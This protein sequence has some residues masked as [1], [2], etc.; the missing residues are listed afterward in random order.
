MKNSELVGI[1]FCC[2][3]NSYKNKLILYNGYKIIL[4]S[5]RGLGI[6]RKLDLYHLRWTAKTL[7]WDINI[8][9]V[10]K[11]HIPYNRSIGFKLTKSIIGLFENKKY[12]LMSRSRIRTENKN[13]FNR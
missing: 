2:L 8:I 3:S 11:C 4:P 5:L 12:F 9:Y 13:F 6:G 1:M 7:L 10:E